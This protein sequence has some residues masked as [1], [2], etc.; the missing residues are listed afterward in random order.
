MFYDEI[1]QKFTIIDIADMS[2]SPYGNDADDDV[3]YFYR[4]LLTLGKFYTNELMTRCGQSFM[5]G[6]REQI[7]NTPIGAQLTAGTPTNHTSSSSALPKFEVGSQSIG[8]SGPIRNAT[9]STPSTR[10][11]TPSTPSKNADFHPPAGYPIRRTTPSTP[12]NKGD[13]LQ[14]SVAAPNHARPTHGYGSINVNGDSQ[15]AG[16]RTPPPN[17]ASRVSIT[18]KPAE[19]RT[20][21]SITTK[22][23]ENGKVVGI[24]TKPPEDNAKVLALET[25]AELSIE[26]LNMSSGTF[27]PTSAG[28]EILEQLGAPDASIQEMPNPGGGSKGIKGIWLVTDAN[29]SFILKLLVAKRRFPSIPTITEKCITLASKCP[30][31][32]ADLSLSFPLIMFKCCEPDGHEAY[33]LLAMREPSGYKL[34]DIIAYRNSSGRLDDLVNIFR[35]F[36]T[37]LANFHADYQMQHGHCHPS[38]VFYDDSTK[39]FTLTDVANMEANPYASND[40]DISYFN[41]ALM[42][43]KEYYGTDLISRC[44]FSVVEGYKELRRIA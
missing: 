10:H 14:A 30:T 27:D 32:K 3:T 37:F 44:S 40:D 18:T 33:D 15:S 21:L 29:Q 20:G 31:I 35:K 2:V 36:G 42:T 22:A 11:T 9:P 12:S 6:Y 39:K 17:L 43:L 25:S 4:A 38:N 7:G 26:T 24:D 28:T 34:A 16:A 13:S 5:T 41:R 19:S 8:M 1:S 23:A